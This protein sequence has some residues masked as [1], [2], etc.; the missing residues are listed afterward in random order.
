LGMVS[1]DAAIGWVL[2]AYEPNRRFL[3]EGKLVRDNYRHF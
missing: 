2:L 3:A 1:V